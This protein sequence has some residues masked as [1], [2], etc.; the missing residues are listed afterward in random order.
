M[1]KHTNR[2]AKATSPYLIQHAH[3]PVDW[4]E[5][6]DEAFAL[7]RK[8]DRPIFLSVG[9]SA[10]HWCHVLAHESFENEEIAEFMNEHFVNIKVDREERP[11]VDR[12]YMTYLQ[13]TQ[14]G[15]GGWPLSVWLNPDLTPFLAGT[16]FP[17]VR[18]LTLCERI[19]QLW[20]SNRSQLK[21]SGVDVISQI[22]EATDSQ[23]AS[24]ALGL[25]PAEELSHRIYTQLQNSFDPKHGGFGTAPKFPSISNTLKPLLLHAAFAS[26][27]KGEEKDR[28]LEMVR[29]TMQKMWRGGIHDWVAGGFARYS[30]D[31]EWKVPHFEKMLYDQPQILLSA[32]HAGLLLDGEERK[33][34]EKIV[35]DVEAYVLRDLRAK[36]GGFYSSEDADS[37]PSASSEKTKEGAFY[38]WEKKEIKEILGDETETFCDMFG[39]K[40]DGNIEEESD[41]H[42]ELTGKNMLVLTD[43]HPSQLPDAIITNLATLKEARDRRPRPHLDDKIV[44]A[45][46]GM[47]ISA[48]AQSPS[49]VG[50]RAAEEAVRFIKEKMWN[51]EAKELCR[52]WRDGRV[53]PRGQSDDYVFVVEGLLD[54]YERTFDD[55]YLA[56]AL[57]LQQTL[58]DKF[59]DDGQGGYFNSPPDRSIL[60]R[61]K[62]S[63]D[64]AEPSANGIALSNLQRLAAFF[65]D[66]TGEW[67]K[68]CDLILEQNKD[69]LK[70]APRAFATTVCGMWMKEKGARE[71]LLYGPI[72]DEKTSQLLAAIRKKFIPNRVLIHVD[73]QNPSALLRDRNET[74]KGLLASLERKE[75]V[76]P[77][78]RV[79]ENRVCGL[80][81]TLEQLNKIL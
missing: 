25:P 48:L 56:F 55:R 16:Y 73:P 50:V 52:S 5:W 75:A 20:E 10:C 44:T 21:E 6:N 30:V 1:T 60:I 36:E 14:H 63:Q 37:L 65:H 81:M 76:E 78:V 54:L 49:E 29:F 72:C 11:D 61:M 62:D 12:L 3:N 22:K 4:Y 19:A 45:W 80:P 17:P 51:V 9:Y 33:G 13:A 28:A 69:M 18:F 70:K 40:E 67:D 57:E 39:V 24:S 27:E 64:G 34:M 41:P 68:K 66:K 7:A 58:D 31:G 42:G 2:L 38:V 59:W 15:R 46:Q 53:G 35:Q 23:A 47:M 77:N 32:H 43:P 79:C 26:P 8:E 71:F 74:V